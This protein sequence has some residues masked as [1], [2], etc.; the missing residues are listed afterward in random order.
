M[1]DEKKK[2]EK[3]GISMYITGETK[4]TLSPAELEMWGTGDGLG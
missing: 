3:N 4:Q 2:K 1:F